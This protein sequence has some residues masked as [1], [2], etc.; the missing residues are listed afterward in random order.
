MNVCIVGW[1]GTETIGDR[2]ILA[3]IMT[4]LFET[5]GEVSIRLGSLHPLFSQRTVKEDAIFWEELAGCSVDVELFDSTYAG[6]LKK[7]IASSDLLLIGGGPLMDLREMH[8]LSFAF[9]TARR[10]GVMCGVF[11]CGIGPV[12]KKVYWKVLEEILNTADFVVLRDSLSYSEFERTGLNEND[13]IHVGIDPAA[14][15]ALQYRQH[16]PPPERVRQIPINFRALSADY[17]QGDAPQRF[18]AFACDLVRRV[19]GRYEDHEILLLPHHYFCFGGD[20]R[21][22]LNRLKF[23]A[24]VDNVRVQNIPLSLKETMDE[25]SSATACIGMRFHAILLMSILCPRCRFLNYTG[26]TGKTMGYL[27]MIDPD[28]YFGTDRLLSL[29]DSEWNP[30]LVDNLC[31]DKPFEIKPEH[32]LSKVDVYR[33]ILKRCG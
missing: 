1:Y 32:I 18:D 15:C 2:A 10:Q 11:G 27:Q 24:G 16:N 4:L 22:F 12:K 21:R 13:S 7:A 17:I 20:D 5:Y 6:E 3:G 31:E 14:Y 9:R 23:K 30:A 26:A 25:F 28:G 8:M 19:A 29:S 33:N